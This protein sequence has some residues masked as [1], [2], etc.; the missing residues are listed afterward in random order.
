MTR[1]RKKALRFTYS[2]SNFSTNF[3]CFNP[4]QCDNF[5]RAWN[6]QHIFSLQRKSNHLSKPLIDQK[7]V[8]FL[9]F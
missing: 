4:S 2:E 7:G 1:A 9:L 8:F 6:Y 5:S 3:S